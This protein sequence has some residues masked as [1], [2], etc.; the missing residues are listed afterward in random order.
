MS[1]QDFSSSPWSSSVR[2][3]SCCRSSPSSHRPPPT[4]P[5]LPR[6]FLK[7]RDVLK[8]FN[9]RNRVFLRTRREASASPLNSYPIIFLEVDFIIEDGGQVHRDGSE[10]RRPMG[11]G[12]PFGLESVRRVDTALPGGDPPIQ[13]RFPCPPGGAAVGHPTG[14]AP[15]VTRPDCGPSSVSIILR[16]RSSRRAASKDRK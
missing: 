1:L 10:G 7:S 8:L 15:V 6:L 12:G 13:W 5:P 4:P 9:P 14:I 16:G 11:K 3:G 2:R